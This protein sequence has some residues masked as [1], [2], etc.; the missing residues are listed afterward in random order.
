MTS[1][2]AVVDDHGQVFSTTLPG[3]LSDVFGIRIAN[4]E[5]VE[6]MNEIS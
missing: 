4:Y 6:I 5:E 3:K 1:H 2:S